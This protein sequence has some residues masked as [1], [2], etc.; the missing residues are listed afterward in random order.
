MYSICLLIFYYTD[1]NTLTYTVIITFIFVSVS[2][3]DK[4]ILSTQGKQNVFSAM[5]SHLGGE[6]IPSLGILLKKI[7]P[8]Q[9]N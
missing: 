9:Y 1:Q 4:G 6:E 7:S 8:E 2:T 5:K 3:S